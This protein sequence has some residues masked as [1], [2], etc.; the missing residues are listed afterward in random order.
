MN[1]I[2]LDVQEVYSPGAEIT[3]ATDGVVFNGE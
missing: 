2:C 3:I 1:Q